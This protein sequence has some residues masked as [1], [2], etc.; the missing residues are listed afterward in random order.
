MTRAVVILVGDELLSGARHD[1]NGAWLLERFGD[2]GVAVAAVHLIGDD[3][4]RLEALDRAAA[5]AGDLVVLSGGLGPTEDD[6]TRAALAAAAGV[7]L[8]FDEQA[9]QAIEACLARRGRAP[10]SPE[11][12]QADVPAGGRWLANPVGIAPGLEL[13]FDG[14]RVVAFPGVP[15]EWR[16]MCEAYVLGGLAASTAVAHASVWAAGV[17]EADV[18]AR[19]EALPELE[20]VALASYPNDGE[21][22]LTLRGPA[23]AVAAAR[24]ALVRAL[25]PDGFTPPPGGAIE[26]AVVRQLAVAG[27]TVAT[28]ESVTGGLIARM[29]TRVPGASAVYPVG[30]VTYATEQKVAQLGVDPGLVA[31]HGVVSGVV[32]RAM[33]EGA[34][35]RAGTDAALATTGTAGPDP[36]LEPGRAPVPPG[37]VHVALAM[38][39]RETADLTLTLPHPREL[40]QRFAA[41]RALDLLRRALP[42]GESPASR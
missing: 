27:R 7:P 1:A 41:V 15:R 6:R 12:R 31:A 4:A 36:L 33:A 37:R 29:L 42:G 17:P 30:W 9:W 11:R 18:A 26:H 3:E 19:I 32:A 34:R 13:E 24:A 8:R 2:L 23:R 40:V 21:V 10:A 14:A 20:G 39:G 35:A 22:E 5:T 25:G 28:A 16:A 38:A